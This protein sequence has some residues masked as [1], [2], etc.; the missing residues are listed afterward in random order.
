MRFRGSRLPCSWVHPVTVTGNASIQQPVSLR[1]SGFN[2]LAASHRR[3]LAAGC[4]VQVLWR[5]ALE[6]RPIRRTAGFEPALTTDW[7]RA[8]ESNLRSFVKL[9]ARAT[10][11]RNECIINK[12]FPAKLKATVPPHPNSTR[13]VPRSF[14]TS[15]LNS[16]RHEHRRQKI[17]MSVVKDYLTTAPPQPR[18]SSRARQVWQHRKARIWIPAIAGC[19]VAGRSPLGSPGL[20]FARAEAARSVVSLPRLVLRGIGYVGQV[21]FCKCAL[22]YFSGVCDRDIAIFTACHMC[23]LHAHNLS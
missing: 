21:P 3:P 14:G 7:S 5:S 17:R 4:R 16:L 23:V 6:L 10:M 9:Y 22:R 12:C 8:Q 15:R 20:R 18:V 2:F 11:V 13:A 1:K 19:R